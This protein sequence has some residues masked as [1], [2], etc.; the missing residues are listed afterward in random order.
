[1]EMKKE[2]RKL[3]S[4]EGGGEREREKEKERRKE[5]EE[6]KKKKKKSKN[7]RRMEERQDDP[8]TQDKTGILEKTSS[9]QL[10]SCQY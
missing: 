2:V 4:Q 5:S 7:K 6:E 10:G 1:M 3:Y 8:T 9:P